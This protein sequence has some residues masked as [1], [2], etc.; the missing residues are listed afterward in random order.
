VFSNVRAEELGQL[1]AVYSIFFLIRRLLDF[2]SPKE[3]HLFLERNR[4]P[5]LTK[6]LLV[7]MEKKDSLPVWAPFFPLKKRESK[8]FLSF[9][10]PC[11]QRRRSS[12]R[13][14]PTFRTSRPGNFTG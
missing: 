3:A 6:R 8:P 13:S 4:I 7:Q 12:G 11:F 2:N 14:L 5:F 10:K 1:R 9:L